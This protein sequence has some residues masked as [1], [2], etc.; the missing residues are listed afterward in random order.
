MNSSF[1][2][3]RP[4]I[5]IENVNLSCLSFISSSDQKSVQILLRQVDVPTFSKVNKIC[6]TYVSQYQDR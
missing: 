5:S 1:I 3:S 2:T 4:E 6:L